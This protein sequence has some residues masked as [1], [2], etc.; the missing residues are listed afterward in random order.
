MYWI[1]ATSSNG[2]AL[3]IDGINEEALTLL[4]PFLGVLGASSSF[5]K[6]DRNGLRI[7]LGGCLGMATDGTD[8]QSLFIETRLTTH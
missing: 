7:L 4:I 1:D 3:Q 6:T 8:G 2:E 5:G